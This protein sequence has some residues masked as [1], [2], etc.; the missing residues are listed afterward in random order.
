MMEFPKGDVLKLE[1]EKTVRSCTPLQQIVLHCF[2]SIFST[3][4]CFRF[5]NV[6]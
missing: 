3:N 5:L 4:V 2:Y 1:N 6:K